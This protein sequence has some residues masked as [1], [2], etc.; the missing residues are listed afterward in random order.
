[1]FF[2]L[3]FARFFSLC[4]CNNPILFK[5]VGIIHSPSLTILI[6]LC[7]LLRQ[8]FVKSFKRILNIMS[9]RLRKINNQRSS[10]RCVPLILYSGFIHLRMNSNK[11][12]IWGICFYVA[13]YPTFPTSWLHPDVFMQFLRVPMKQK[14]R[15]THRRCLCLY[16]DGTSATWWFLSEDRESGI[17]WNSWLEHEDSHWSG[18]CPTLICQVP[19]S[20]GWL[21]SGRCSC[22]F[23]LL[24][25][26]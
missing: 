13:A 23:Y 25:L 22:Y 12:I 5:V 9:Q 3:L 24:Q 26:L 4:L 15:A 19:F 17:F 18:P 16:Q 10:W 6:Y 2:C 7:I 8:L 21:L 1:M 20:S 14:L 11:L